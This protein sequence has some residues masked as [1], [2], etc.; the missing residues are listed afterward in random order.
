[1]AFGRVRVRPTVKPTGPP[2]NNGDNTK[3][4]K[5]A[6]PDDFQKRKE[7]YT[8]FFV[9][10]NSQIKPRDWNHQVQIVD[11]MEDAYHDLFGVPGNPRSAQEDLQVFQKLFL[12]IS[13]SQGVK[14]F[15]DNDGKEDNWRDVFN[16][17]L[18]VDIEPSN[19]IEVG[20]KKKGGRVHSH[21]V[22]KV[23]HKTKIHLNRAYIKEVFLNRL[24]RFGVTN[25]H[26]YIR[27][28]GNPVESVEDY[29]QKAIDYNRNNKTLSR[30]D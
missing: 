4:G 28:F 22:I 7:T 6:F 21:T 2:G 20:T 13:P 16:H 12:L 26:I 29:L 17:N 25:P 30:L 15:K 14:G 11:A 23:K 18:L 19:A 24:S 9:T 1:M 8:T 5:Y 10:V 3:K 27:A